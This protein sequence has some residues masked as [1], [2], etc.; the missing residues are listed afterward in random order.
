MMCENEIEGGDTGDPYPFQ[1]AAL[2]VNTRA[3]ARGM[4]PRRVTS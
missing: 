1:R 3:R 2:I 4:S